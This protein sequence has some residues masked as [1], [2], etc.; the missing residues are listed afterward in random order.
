MEYIRLTSELLVGNILNIS[1]LICL[2][3]VK[4]FQVVLSNS[5]KIII[6]FNL[7]GFRYCYLTLPT[8][9]NIS[10]LFAHT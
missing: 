2:P 1:E 5:N 6:C 8:Q 9:I 3:T 10:H 4:W 7:N